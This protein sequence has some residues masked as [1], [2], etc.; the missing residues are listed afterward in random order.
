MKLNPSPSLKR[1]AKTP[2][3][4]ARDKSGLAL[5][6][7]AF[8]MPLVLM[9]GLYGIET[10]NMALI[11][12]K[13]S[14]ITLSLADNASRVGLLNSVQI[15]QLREVDINDVLQA[16]RSQG[17]NI[18]LTTNGRITL[19]SLEKDSG[20]TQRAH[21]QRCLG[22]MSGTGYDSSITPATYNPSIT[23][24]SDTTAGNSGT[25]APLGVGEAGATKVQAP[26]GGGV[27]YVEVNYQYKPVV[28]NWLFGVSRI[29]YVASF[30]IRDN[31][32]FSQIFNPS[33]AVTTANK[34]TCNLYT[35]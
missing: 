12:L 21:W 32:D 20:G 19:T 7:F 6:E 33:P 29:H 14:Q 15:E 1:L 10:A 2:G 23:A 4:L 31:R 8:A 26:T 35:S 17:A 18:A 30:I 16:A 25:L 11:N 3:R 24:G 9:V 34:A 27:I 22:R 5:L 13:V 28:G